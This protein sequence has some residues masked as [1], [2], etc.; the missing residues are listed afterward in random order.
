ML[1]FSPLDKLCGIPRNFNG[2][3]FCTVVRPVI[4]GLISV[5]FGF[6][7]VVVTASTR[8]LEVALVSLMVVAILLYRRSIVSLFGFVCLLLFLAYLNIYRKTWVA[9]FDPAAPFL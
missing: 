1:V 6:L 9:V 7:P 2:L 3:R 5:W 8:F 4:Y